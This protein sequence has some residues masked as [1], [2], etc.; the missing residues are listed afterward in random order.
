MWTSHIFNVAASMCVTMRIATAAVGLLSILAA[1]SFTNW[2][3]VQSE[4]TTNNELFDPL[5]PHKVPVCLVCNRFVP[6]MDKTFLGE[7]LLKKTINRLDSSHIR[8]PDEIRKYYKGGSAQ[9]RRNNRYIRKGLLSPLASEKIV[10]GR[11]GVSEVFFSSCVTCKKSLEQKTDKPPALA[12]A[13]GNWKGVAPEALSKL[14]DIERTVVSHHRNESHVYSFFAGQQK[15]MQG[16]H[17]MVTMDPDNCNMALEHTESVQHQLGRQSGNIAVVFH[18]KFTKKQKKKVE[19]ET[20]VNLN[21]VLEAF[22]FLHSHNNAYTSE[23]QFREYFENA[24]VRVDHSSVEDDTDDPAEMMWEKVTFLPDIADINSGSGS[25]SSSE[26]FAARV[27]HQLSSRDDPNSLDTLEFGR[28]QSRSRDYDADFLQKAFPVQFPYGRGGLDEDRPQK[29]S[30]EELLK[31][32][33][34]VADPS[35]LEPN[36]ILSVHTLFEKQRSL[37]RA[38]IMCQSRTAGERLGERLGQ[39]TQENFNRMVENPYSDL[40]NQFLSSVEASCKSM[41]HTNEAAKEARNKMFSQWVMHGEPAIFFTVSPCDSV[42][43]RIRLY[44]RPT[45]EH[46]FPR[47]DA[48]NDVVLKEYEVRAKDRLERPGACSLDFIN[49]MEFV[50]KHI[51]G[52]DKKNHCSF[53]DDHVG[54]FGEIDAFAEAVEEQGR[55]TLHAHCVIW[56]KTVRDKIRAVTKRGDTPNDL[57]GTSSDENKFLLDYFEQVMSCSLLGDSFVCRDCE[58]DNSTFV[59]VDKQVVRD[60]RHKRG[61]CVHRGKIGFCESCGAAAQSEETAASRLNEWFNKDLQPASPSHVLDTEHTLAALAMS[62]IYNCI[63]T[64]P[65]DELK[66]RTILINAL[67]NLH[68]CVHARSCF[69]KGPGAF[70]QKIDFLCFLDEKRIFCIFWEKNMFFMTG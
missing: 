41:A 1:R 63:D 55:G 10:R 45:E 57:S 23:D 16:F 37:N 66:R 70:L 4:S 17:T 18:G 24:I 60:M 50:T 68:R 62:H 48:D 67:F 34:T 27:L 58:V 65:A 56:I 13:N 43:F 14:K 51:I 46:W 40:E 32:Y 36:F 64:L 52:W 5:L 21:N 2:S 54:A 47:L 61:S 33:L 38:F 26:E 28:S 7:N 44:A 31:L 9:Y 25:C 8:L 35:V 19:E 69:K 3:Q 20:T 30:D 12:I 59:Q 22:R 39:L 42:N 6:L 29:V 15:R 53:K 49:Q 11:N